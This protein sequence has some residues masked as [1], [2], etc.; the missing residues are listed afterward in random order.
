MIFGQDKETK[1]KKQHVK[2]SMLLDKMVPHQVFLLLP[3]QLANEQWVWLQSVWRVARFK[4][5][6]KYIP[7]YHYCITEKDAWEIT[8]QY[9]PVKCRYGSSFLVEAAQERL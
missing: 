7:D 1:L 2:L 3:R 5:T 6:L 4:E 8:R 9:N